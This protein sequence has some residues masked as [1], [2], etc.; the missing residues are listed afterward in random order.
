MSWGCYACLLTRA[1]A[2]SWVEA[3]PA[4]PTKYRLDPRRGHSRWGWLPWRGD[5]MRHTGSEVGA[6]L[7]A[8][9]ALCFKVPKLPATPDGGAALH[10]V[11]VSATLASRR[12][13]HTT[14]WPW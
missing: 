7:Q 6:G 5:E 10:P 2:T 13:T 1:P 9:K 14:S 4:H 12:R 8:T 11:S 3:V